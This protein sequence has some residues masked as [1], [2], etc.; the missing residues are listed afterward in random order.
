MWLVP[1]PPLRAS[2]A[3][4]RRVVSVAVT[5]L[6]AALSLPLGVVLATPAAAWDMTSPFARE[7]VRPGDVDRDVYDI[8]HVHE[9]QIRLR[10]LGLLRAAPDGVYGPRTTRA[11]RVFQRRNGLR[12][13]GTVN[14]R[15]WQPLIRKSLRGRAKVPAVCRSAG[16]HVCYDRSWNQAS[17]YRDGRIHNSWLVRGGAADSKTRVGSFTVYRRS[18]DHVSNLY[19]APMPYAQFFSGGQAV[20]GSRAMVNPLEGHS[21]GCVNFWV[22]DARQLWRLTHDEHLRVHVYGAWR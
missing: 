20:H 5:L 8:E 17:L 4:R 21:H 16:W 22:E 18:K 12:V 1:T 2:A 7:V 15:T 10:R 3:L 13:T 11:V 9:V 14:Y 19:D 6:A